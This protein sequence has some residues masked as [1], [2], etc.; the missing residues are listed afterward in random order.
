MVI[1]S[2]ISGLLHL[3]SICFMPHPIHVTVTE[4][5]HDE[6]DRRVEIMLRVFTDDLELALRKDLGQPDLDLLQPKGSLTVDQMIGKYVEKHLKISVDNKPL[7]LTYL[8]HEEDSDA[9]VLYIEG[10]NVKKLK[11]IMV[12]N[13]F[14]T[15]V[16]E[17]QSNLV[18]VT[19]KGK[20]KSLRLTRNTPTDKLT[21][22]E[23]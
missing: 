9:F 10:P 18:H 14:L 12:S 17:D 16:H 11:T 6:K 19:V 8:G 2:Y 22:E 13:D 23:K 7:K 21:F 4:M 3:V 1:L 20:V 15:E 5:E